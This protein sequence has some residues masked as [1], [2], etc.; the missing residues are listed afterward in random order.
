M[1]PARRNS[2]R[3]LRP[4]RAEIDACRQLL[5]FGRAVLT[6]RTVGDRLRAISDLDDFLADVD[7][8]LVP[9]DEDPSRLC[10]RA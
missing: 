5:F 1:S 4:N 9:V 10:V 3:E 2:L 6:G 8:I 7:I